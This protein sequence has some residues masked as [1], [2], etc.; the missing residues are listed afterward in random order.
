M[1][2]DKVNRNRTTVS[3]ETGSA[4]ETLK[5]LAKMVARHLLAKRKGVDEQRPSAHG[6]D[7]QYSFHQ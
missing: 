3:R 2:Q 1:E 4:S 5:I 7:T 6:P